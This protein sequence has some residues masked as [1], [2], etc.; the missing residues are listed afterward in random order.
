[1]SELKRYFTYKKRYENRKS[2]KTKGKCIG[3][4]QNVGTIFGY[5]NNIYFARCGSKD[6]PCA[7]DIRIQRGEYVDI[8]ELK[9]ETLDSINNLKEDIIRLKLDVLFG[10]MN[11]EA[12]I[13]LFQEKKEEIDQLEDTLE[14]YQQAIDNKLQV[15][16]KESSLKELKA[17]RSIAL[18]DIKEAQ[19]EYKNTGNKQYLSSILSIYIDQLLR[20]HEELRDITYEEYDVEENGN[21]K[22]VVKKET[23]LLDHVV[24][25]SPMVVESFKLKNKN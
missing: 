22:K 5:E 18:Q 11:E 13:A 2:D 21:E 3:C 19:K 25:I 10:F 7:L 24:E 9:K 16:E 17:R 6:E 8:Y 4:N 15:E 23:N 14:Y 12:M 1:M 20:L